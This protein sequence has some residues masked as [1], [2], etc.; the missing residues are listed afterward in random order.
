MN[1]RN[2]K[3][4]SISGTSSVFF[5]AIFSSVFLDDQLHKQGR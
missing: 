3:K 2:K 1:A 4:L 5:P